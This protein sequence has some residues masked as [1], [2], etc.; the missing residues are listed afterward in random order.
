MTTRLS[1]AEIQYIVDGV[2]QDFRSD[3]RGAEDY[4]QIELETRILP[5]TN[6]SARCKLGK[7]EVLVGVKA[8][9]VDV[10]VHAPHIGKLVIT[11]DCS[12]VAS[13][14]FV[15]KGSEALENDLTNVLSFLYNSTNTISLKDLCIVKGESCWQLHVDVLFVQ[16]GGNLFDVASIAL[17]AALYSTTLPIVKVSGEG[18]EMEMEVSD[19]PYH[20]WKLDVSNCPICITLY[21]IGGGFA[22]D[23][24]EEEVACSEGF[25]HV[26]VQPNGD[27][28][29]MEKAG[30][31]NIDPTTLLEMVEVG[32]RVGEEIHKQL[33]KQL[34]AEKSLAKL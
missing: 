19:D 13:P 33:N 23:P 1:N 22:V 20:V 5:N 17:K 30:A 16:C 12:A 2:E 7:T 18:I 32:V 10:D 15:G 8:E 28:S 9:V 31:G 3:G 21:Q 34:D 29:S 6:G 26:G 4:R 14:K 25:V 11:A 27:M 24:S